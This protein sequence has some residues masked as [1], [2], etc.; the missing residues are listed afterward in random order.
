MASN[1][2]PKGGGLYSR[3]VIN[4]ILKARKLAAVGFLDGAIAEFCDVSR[5]TVRK[6]KKEHPEFAELITKLRDKNIADG[7]RALKKSAC[8]YDILETKAFVVGKEIK[9]IQIKRHYAPNPISLQYFLGNLDPE[10]WRH[11]RDEPE[12]TDAAPLPVSVNFIAQGADAADAA[13]ETKPS[14]VVHNA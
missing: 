1:G 2:R 6:W 10:N 14:G 3:E 7:V 13:T 4:K 11:R 9:T 5:E 8:G 12:Q